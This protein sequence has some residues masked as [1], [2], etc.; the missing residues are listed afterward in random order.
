[1]SFKIPAG[2]AAPGKN[3]FPFTCQ[4]QGDLSELKTLE[5]PTEPR[6][7][8]ENAQ[9]EGSFPRHAECGCCCVFLLNSHLVLEDWD[10][11]ELCLGSRFCP[12]LKTCPGQLKPQVGKWDRQFPLG[13]RNFQ[14]PAKAVGSEP[15]NAF[16]AIIPESGNLG[17]LLCQTR[18][19]C[20]ILG[21]GTRWDCW[22]SILL[23]LSAA[24]R[25]K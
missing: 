23:F 25:R 24:R 22:I 11:E 16:L 2:A 10:E 3:P 12:A 4:A 18:R 19:L 21:N 13:N 14:R 6:A 7:S 8:P 20:Q 15:A 9:Q 1:M 5:V 17:Y